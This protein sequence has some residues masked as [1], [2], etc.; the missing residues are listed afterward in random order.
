MTFDVL[1]QGLHGPPLR[2]THNMPVFLKSSSGV[3]M[4]WL[5]LYYRERC[6]L[7]KQFARGCV[8]E[9][10]QTRPLDLQLFERWPQPVFRDLSNRIRIDISIRE[11]VPVQF[12]TLAGA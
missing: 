3:A 9:S 8:T 7:L 10:V 4:T 12:L 5:A 2:V 6:A 1:G 11:Q